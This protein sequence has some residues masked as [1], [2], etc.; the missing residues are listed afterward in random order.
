[1]TSLG[2]P[3]VFVLILVRVGDKPP[4]IRTAADV[5]RIRGVKKSRKKSNENKCQMKYL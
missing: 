1:M 3:S 4:T 5:P 2:M